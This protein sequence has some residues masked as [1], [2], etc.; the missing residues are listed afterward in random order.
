[1]TT[2]LSSSSLN[3]SP[4]FDFFTSFEPSHYNAWEKRIR[5]TIHL[6]P[7]VEAFC[8]GQVKA[9]CNAST[10]ALRARSDEPGGDVTGS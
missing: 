10:E 2:L 1:M 8:D 4:R 5:G 9:L 3:E 6:H 7:S